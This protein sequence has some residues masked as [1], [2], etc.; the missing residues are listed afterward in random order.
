MYMNT[1]LGLDG[2][3]T[4]GLA[5]ACKCPGTTIQM[6]TKEEGLAEE[7]NEVLCSLW[8]PQQTDLLLHTNRTRTFVT[9]AIDA[10]TD[11]LLVAHGHC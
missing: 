10:S 11:G 3:S 8:M 1:P 4:E 6:D 5:D 2:C 9:F 7:L